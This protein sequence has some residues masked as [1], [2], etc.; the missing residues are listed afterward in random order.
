MAR[1][2]LNHLSDWAIGPLFIAVSVAIALVGWW[3]MRRFLPGW[4]EAKSA[5]QVVGVAQMVMTMFALVLAFVIINLYSGFESAVENVS[6]EAN[7]LSTLVRDAQV[8]PAPARRRIDGAV[9]AYVEV[10]QKREFMLLRKGREDPEA[11]R[12]LGLIF[13]A[14]Q[15]YSPVAESQRAFYRSAAD[16]L[17][18]VAGERQK[19]VEAAETSIPGPLLALL[20]VSALMLLGASLL[21]KAHRPA[22][23][24]ALV[25]SVA[26]IVG[27][28][29]FT[30]LILEYPFSGS[31]AVSSGPFAHVEAGL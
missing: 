10:V 25:V 1:S 28:G 6:A 17:N 18:A 24:I 19:R 2:L 4:R 14:V 15:S 23:D 30:A 22:V 27:V 13:S 7:S 16:Q 20:V 26:V 11:R 31:L 21:I 8:F 29:L 3:L 5:E 9:A 12:N